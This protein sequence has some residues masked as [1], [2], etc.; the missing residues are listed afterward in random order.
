MTQNDLKSATIGDSHWY[1]I[2]YRTMGRM[3]AWL[4]TLLLTAL[5]AAMSL[6]HHFI[7]D[8]PRQWDFGAVPDVPGQS[9]YSSFPASDE[10]P[11]STRQLIPLPGAR[12]LTGGGVHE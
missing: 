2:P 5:V 3:G 8:Q 12:P 10:L 1:E 9:I 11:T 4:V 6:L 7:M